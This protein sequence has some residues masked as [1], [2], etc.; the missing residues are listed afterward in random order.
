MSNPGAFLELL[1]GFKA[2]IDAEDVP[3][4]NFKAIRTTLADP[5]FTPEIIMGKSSAAAGLCDWIINITSYYD[6][7][8]SVEPKKLAVAEAQATLAAA[9]AKKAEVDERVAKLNA[10]LKVLMDAFQKAMDEKN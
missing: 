6:V 9:N 5:N 3:A 7:V 10:E 8:V 1:N 4:I 2:K